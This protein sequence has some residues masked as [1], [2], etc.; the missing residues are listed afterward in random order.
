MLVILPHFL[1][2]LVEAL[3]LEVGEQLQ[4]VVHHSSGGVAWMELERFDGGKQIVGHFGAEKRMTK[5]IYVISIV[6]SNLSCQLRTLY[7]NHEGSE[8][9]FKARVLLG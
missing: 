9:C 6:T 4:V 1:L 3:L 7:R 5:I 2:E 8:R